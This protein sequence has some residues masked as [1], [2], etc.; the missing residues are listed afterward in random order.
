[1]KIVTAEVFVTC[2]GRNI[3]QDAVT[4]AAPAARIVLMGFSTEPSQ[5]ARQGMTAKALSLFSSRL[6]AH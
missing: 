2:P 4:L 3:F 6:N 5:V 1:M